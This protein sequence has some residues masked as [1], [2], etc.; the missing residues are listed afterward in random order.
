MY[1]SIYEFY[2]IHIYTCIYRKFNLVHLLYIPYILYILYYK[3]T[4]YAYIYIVCCK[5]NYI[6]IYIFYYIYFWALAI[7]LFSKQRMRKICIIYVYMFRQLTDKLT[8]I[9][10]WRTTHHFWPRIPCELMPAISAPILRME[11]LKRNK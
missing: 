7:T 1:T 10:C 8:W 11:L 5:Y 4:I 9:G 6:N 2:N 3:F